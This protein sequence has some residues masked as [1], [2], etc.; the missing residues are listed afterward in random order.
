MIV[1]ADRA[2]VRLQ[3]FTLDGKLIKIVGD[4]L[5]HPCHFSQRGTDLLIPDLKGRVT[6]FDKDNKLVTHLGDNPNKEQWA[7]NAVKPEELK[8]GVFCTPHGASW[9]QNGNAYIVE[10]LPY[11][12]ITKLKRVTA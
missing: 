12:R 11:G 2:N 4:E 6:I 5:R 7:K 3:W 9:D 1:V 10:W 8:P